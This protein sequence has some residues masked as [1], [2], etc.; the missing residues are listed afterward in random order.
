MPIPSKQRLLKVAKFTI[1]CDVEVHA[2]ESPE[3]WTTMTASRFLAMQWHGCQ[4]GSAR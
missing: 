3:T 2:S 1:K 4:E